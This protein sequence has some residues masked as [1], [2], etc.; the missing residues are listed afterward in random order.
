MDLSKVDAPR[1]EISILHQ[2]N[3]VNTLY[4]KQNKLFQF[5][6]ELKVLGDENFDRPKPIFAFN[7]LICTMTSG[8]QA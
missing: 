4:F 1:G 8:W 3:W 2:R 5:N 7:K 6:F